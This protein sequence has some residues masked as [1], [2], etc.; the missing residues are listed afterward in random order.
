MDSA[1][2]PCL[3]LSIGLDCPGEVAYDIRPAGRS[4][5]LPSRQIPL[6]ALAT[7]Q[8]TILTEDNLDFFRHKGYLVRT[9]LLSHR[10]I[11]ELVGLFDADRKKAPLR[12][13]RRG[14]QDGNYDALVTTPEFDRVVRHPRIMQAVEELMG[15]PVCF[16]EIGIR[17]MGPYDGKVKQHWHRDRPHWGAHP[18]RM[19]YIQLMLYLTDVDQTTHC[20]SFSPESIDEPV[21]DDNAKQLQRAG[22]VHIHG[23]AGTVCLFNVALLHT[24]TTRPTRNERKT[25]QVYYGHRGSPYLANDSVIP[26]SFWKDHLD[27]EVRSFYGNLNEITRI[28][29]RAFGVDEP[30]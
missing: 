6:Q 26:S 16:G 25:V 17:S 18:L 10:E 24:A 11:G 15:G 21:L 3:K 2:L 4:M 27:P 1:P 13:M 29:M 30:A 9:D 7:F 28:Y 8:M 23:Q 12:W 22:C 20:F 14:T 5:D 19:D